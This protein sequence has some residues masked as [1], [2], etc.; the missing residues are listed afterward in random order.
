V[1]PAT[2]LAE[3]GATAPEIAEAYLDGRQ[4][5]KGH[6]PVLAAPRRAGCARYSE[7]GRLSGQAAAGGIPQSEKWA[8]GE[9]PANIFGNWMATGGWM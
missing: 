8:M 4:G 3:A 5:P 1:A 7:A 9:R 6:W 2:L